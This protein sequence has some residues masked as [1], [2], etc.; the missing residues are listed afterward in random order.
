MCPQMTKATFLHRK[1]CQ[2]LYNFLP[3]PNQLLGAP[4]LLY[5]WPPVTTSERPWVCACLT[6]QETRVLTEFCSCS[7]TSFP[8]APSTNDTA[9]TRGLIWTKPCLGTNHQLQLGK[10]FPL[11]YKQLPLNS[12][13]TCS[14]SFIPAAPL[15]YGCFTKD[16]HLLH[17]FA[18]W[19]VPRTGRFFLLGTL[20]NIAVYHSNE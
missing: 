20:R 10:C 17:R 1:S 7:R 11:G 3:T 9:D 2:Q 6:G 4:A 16:T 15:I 8:C 13:V 5:R 19:S 18:S 14:F 12:R